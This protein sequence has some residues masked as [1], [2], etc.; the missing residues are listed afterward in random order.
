MEK[1]NACK[2]INIRV[3]TNKL[4][5]IIAIVIMVLSLSI[6]EA[7]NFGYCNGYNNLPKEDTF[8]N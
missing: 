2:E 5:F 8:D 1:E 6:A 3:S 4:F 7:Y